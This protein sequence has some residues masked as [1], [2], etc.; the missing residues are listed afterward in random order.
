MSPSKYNQTNTAIKIGF[1]GW[2]NHII[3]PNIMRYK[4]IAINK[5]KT[6][7]ENKMKL[8]MSYICRFSFY[9]S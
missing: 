9:I 2:L 8:I 3:Y 5:N 1:V 4:G 7:A 6:I